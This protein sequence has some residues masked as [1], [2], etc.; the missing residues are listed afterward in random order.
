VTPFEF[1]RDIRHNGVAGLS[2]GV[3]RVFLRLAVSVGLEHRLVTTNN[4]KLDTDHLVIDLHMRDAAKA[5]SALPHHGL[6][7]SVS[8]VLMATG[9]VN[10]R[11]QFSTLCRIDTP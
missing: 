9:F 2:R 7:G 3:L 4:F 6:R 10:G 5:E 8:P 11:W 1:C